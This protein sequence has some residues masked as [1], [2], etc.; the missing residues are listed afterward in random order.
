MV[1][2]TKIDF[3]LF[4]RIGAESARICDGLTDAQWEAPSNCAGW[5]VKHLV[6]HQASGTTY[7]FPKMLG[8]L[9]RY[10]QPARAGHQMALD[11]GN[12]L[13]RADIMAEFRRGHGDKPAN[14]FARISD[15]K[16][17][18]LDAAV[19]LQDL[20]RSVGDDGEISREQ[21]EILF[22]LIPVTAGA[23]GTKAAVAGL[24]LHATD[25]GRS[26]GSG[27]VVQG[28]FEAIMMAAGGRQEALTE[29]SGPGLDT[30][31]ERIGA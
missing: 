4:A 12:S 20:R 21:Q 2:P 22:D 13:N 25:L 7:S 18:V 30:L 3:A 6:A 9:V 24:T 29:L 19:H 1:S 23:T 14:L 28:R 11:M 17:S 15:L 16:H 10:R 5:K 8:Y 31:R 26:V 27:P